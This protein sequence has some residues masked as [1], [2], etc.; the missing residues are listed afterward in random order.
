MHVLC[1]V[2]LKFALPSIPFAITSMIVVHTQLPPISLLASNRRTN[3]YVNSC[4]AG[5]H[6]VGVKTSNYV[7]GGPI[8]RI[9][10]HLPE[11]I[12]SGDT[13]L[14]DFP[15]LIAVLGCVAFCSAMC[16]APQ[17]F[18]QQKRFQ[19]YPIL[20]RLRWKLGARGTARKGGMLS[21]TTCPLEFQH[22]R[23]CEQKGMPRQGL[24]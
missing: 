6:S 15:R 24:H 14:P 19:L 1:Q 16:A 11:Q 2:P 20:Y 10:E 9:S 22:R 21:K 18:K 13:R 8:W 4:T 12:Q 23:Q 7:S 17:G 5:L 3:R